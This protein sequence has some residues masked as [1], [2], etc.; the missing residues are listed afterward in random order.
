MSINPN[1]IFEQLIEN[2]YDQSWSIDLRNGG[3]QIEYTNKNATEELLGYTQEEFY[4]YPELWT[5]IIHPDDL[6]LVLEA[7]LECLK[8]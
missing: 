6:P 2:N 5:S 4:N 1:D 8:R 3:F 7:N